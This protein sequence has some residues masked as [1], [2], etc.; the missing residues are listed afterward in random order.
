VTQP[1]VRG[2]AVAEV[3]RV[4]VAVLVFLPPMLVTVLTA[5]F[6]FMGGTLRPWQPQM[7]DLDVYRRAGDLLLSGGSAIYATPNGELPFLYPPFAAVMGALWDLPSQDIAQVLWLALNVLALLAILHRLGLR[8][9]ILSIVAAACCGLVPPVKDTLAFGQLGIFLVALPLCDLLPGPRLLPW[10]RL[11]P[12]GTSTGFAAALKLTPLIFV[13]YLWLVRHRRSSITTFV[14]FGVLTLLSFVLLPGAS[15]DFFGRLLHGDTGLGDSIAYYTN[16]SIVSDWLRI[17]GRTGGLAAVGL[18]LGAAVALLGIL[19]GA[20][21]YRLGHPAFAL[22]LVGMAGLIASP[23]SWSHHFVWIVPLAVIATSSTLPPTLRALSWL[24][25]LWMVAQ[26]F[27][28]LPHGGNLEYAWTPAQHLLGSVTTLLV[29][30]LLVAAL[31]VRT[32]RLSPVRTLP[33]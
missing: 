21:W 7:M 4:L 6:A 22:C 30:A 19:G 9:W 1:P 10:R 23:V 15:L 29:V 27:T 11:L 3:R 25:T 5:P 8:T 14:A 32:A 31:T 13:P 28:R 12:V 2:R 17:T 20:R 26:P 24:V 33:S 18:L 16:Q